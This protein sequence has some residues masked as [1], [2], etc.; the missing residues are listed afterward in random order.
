MERG[1]TRHALLEQG[2]IL[3]ARHGLDDVSVRQL[4]DAVGARNASAL[5][6]HFGSKQGLVTEILR[7]HLQAI[8]DRRAPLV[9]AIAAHGLEGDLR[10]LVHALAA[11]MA[12]DLESALGRAHLRLVAQFSHPSLAYQPP[13]QVVPAPAGAAVARWLAAATEHLPGAVR[14]ER[15]AAL[16][17]QLIAMFALRAQ[18]LDEDADHGA[19]TALFVHNLL[20]MLVAGLA[21]NASPETTDALAH[22]G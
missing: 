15:L 10:A 19:A 2:A 14:R 9:A 13:F 1:S 16:R 4:H 3:F 21:V 8:E 11:P 5:Q 12:V 17:E 7:L 20:D 18:L 6:Y 22:L